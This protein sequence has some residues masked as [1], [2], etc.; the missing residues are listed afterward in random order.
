MCK[1]SNITEHTVGPWR[2]A[3]PALKPDSTEDHHGYFVI[4]GGSSPENSSRD[5]AY[6]LI[7]SQSE[8]TVS[9]HDQR[10]C[11]ANAYLIAAAPELL[12]LAHTFLSACHVRTSILKDELKEQWCDTEDVQDQIG[13]WNALAELCNRV[14]AKTQ[15]TPPKSR[16]ARRKQASP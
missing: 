12:S 5:I 1:A 3:F 11:L 4:Y 15:S 7:T 14:I 6:S 8:F 16:V 9:T 2:I 13:H 10:E